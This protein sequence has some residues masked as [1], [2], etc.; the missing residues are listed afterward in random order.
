[1]KGRK[2]ASTLALLI[3][4]SVILFP[5]APVRASFGLGPLLAILPCGMSGLIPGDSFTITVNADEIGQFNSYDITLKYSTT[6]L[7]ATQATILPVFGVTFQRL[8]LVVDD[9]T[10]TV[11]V[12]AG[13]FGS[14]VSVSNT[15]ALFSVKFVVEDFGTSSLSM[16]N[17]KIALGANLIQH[18]TNSC[19][20]STIAKP[21][22]TSSALTGWKIKPDIQHMHFFKT[23][24]SGGTIQTLFA[25][26]AN[27]GTTK[28][29]VKVVF[30]VG[31]TQIIP[32]NLVTLDP[33]SFTTVS[34]QPF[35]VTTPGVYS[36]V[37]LPF[38]SAEGALFFQGENSAGEI[39]KAD[40]V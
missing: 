37:G 3:S 22:P 28:A 23:G 1:M 15:Q 24:A 14:T 4:L 18:S 34:T 29:T 27:T 6:V 40:T 25:Q 5:L 17:D 9:S 7:T 26:I 35:N 10:G 38:N 21:P 32:S 31:L 19:S 8:I 13:L 30:F 36:V 20:V 16:V 2:T 11:R 12:S 33:G 39:F